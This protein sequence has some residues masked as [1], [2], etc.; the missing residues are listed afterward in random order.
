MRSLHP[1]QHSTF[2]AYDLIPVIIILS[3]ILLIILIALTSEVSY[4][5]YNV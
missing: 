2:R 4:Y 1:K 3:V 5:A